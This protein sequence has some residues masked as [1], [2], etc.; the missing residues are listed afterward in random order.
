ML[1][2]TIKPTN[3]NSNK[4]VP[5]EVQ[6]TSPLNEEPSNVDVRLHRIS[7]KNCLF[8][9]GITT[10]FAKHGA[11]AKT[12]ATSPDNKTKSLHSCSSLP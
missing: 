7:K 4:M 3:G 10:G 8:T 11:M 12:R 9:V 6:A 5:K 2:R 1:S